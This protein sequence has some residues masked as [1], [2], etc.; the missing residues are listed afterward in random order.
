MDA[1]SNF[2]F[3]KVYTDKMAISAIDFLKI[4]VLLIYGQ[5]HIP[6]DRI[7]TDMAEMYHPLGMR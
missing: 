2:G 1:Y 5:F 4:K 6:L 3:A 7:L